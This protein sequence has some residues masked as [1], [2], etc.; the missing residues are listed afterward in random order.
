MGRFYFLEVG[1][2]IYASMFET[3][4]VFIAYAVGNVYYP[5]AMFWNDFSFFLKDNY[6]VL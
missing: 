6:L 2:F 5:L 1:T 4:E 3:G